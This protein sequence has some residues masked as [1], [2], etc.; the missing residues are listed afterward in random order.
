MLVHMIARATPDGLCSK[1]M[2]C[3]AKTSQ[4]VQ[5]FALM[6]KV[7]LILRWIGKPETANVSAVDDWH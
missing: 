6:C 7:F 5:N 2:I 3:G 1:S 4:N